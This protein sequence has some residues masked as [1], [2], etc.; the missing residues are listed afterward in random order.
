MAEIIYDAKECLINQ[1][2]QLQRLKDEG[3]CVD[4]VC[5]EMWGKIKELIE[6]DDKER[7]AGCRKKL[8]EISRKPSEPIIGCW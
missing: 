4:S 2:A 7:L 6:N 3:L 1:L 8:R 5:E